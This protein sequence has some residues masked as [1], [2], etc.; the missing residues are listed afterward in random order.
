LKKLIEVAFPLNASHRAASWECRQSSRLAATRFWWSKKSQI[1]IRALIFAAL[2]DDP[3]ANPAAFPT[4]EAQMAERDR[5]FGILEKILALKESADD[6]VLK[7]A[8]AEIQKSL[9]DS[10]LSFFDPFAG[11][12]SFALEAQRLGLKVVASDLNPVA[13]AINKAL[14]EIPLKF[15]DLSPVN[16]AGTW[17]Y[18]ERQWSGS[19]GLAEDFVHYAEVLRNR[20]SRLL[21]HLYPFAKT[22]DS[23]GEVKEI[24]VFA[25]LW[26]R[27]IKCPYAH[28][29]HVIPLSRSFALSRRKTNVYAYPVLNPDRVTF[30]IQKGKTD[31]KGSFDDRGPKCLYCES[32]LDWSYVKTE[33]QNGGLD[34]T[35]MAIVGETQDGGLTYLSP[36]VYHERV[37]SVPRPYLPF[38]QNLDL[39]L[40]TSKFGF[41]RFSSLFTARQL[42]YLTTLLDLTKDLAKEIKADALN[43]GLADDDLDLELGGLGAKAYSQAIVVYLSLLLYQTIN[44][45]STIC[46]WDSFHELVSHTI[47]FQNLSMTWSFAENNPLN[48]N[49]TKIIF[50]IGDFIKNLPANTE[51]YAYK[52][53]AKI[54][55]LVRNSLVF[56]DTPFY[57]STSLASVSDFFYIFLRQSLESV[58]S[59][60]FNT[61]L[62]P[63]NGELLADP[64][65]RDGDLTVARQSFAADLKQVLANVRQNQAPSSPSLFY[66]EFNPKDFNEN[67]PK[68]KI[69][70]PGWEDFVA[71]LIEAGFMVTALWPL[72]FE[73]EYKKVSLEKAPR[74]TA[75]IVVCR[76]RPLDA[77]TRLRRDFSRQ[78]FEELPPI[79]AELIRLRT[80]RADMRIVT[81]GFALNVFSRHEAVVRTDGSKISV[82]E[83]I[84][85]IDEALKNNKGFS[86]GVRPKVEDNYPPALSINPEDDDQIKSYQPQPL[87]LKCPSQITDPS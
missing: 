49:F 83:A 36:S 61:L 47:D 1:A 41:N 87:T 57:S 2:V 53:N 64:T 86:G 22:P 40:R 67:C 12:G 43:A 9:G 11:D 74:P 78:L 17:L 23:K 10:A 75:I 80:H 29:G 31:K 27:T 8:R 51:A 77:Q 81:L 25:W 15:A 82:K 35:L 44:Y 45:N 62:V 46:E 58:Y 65:L 70:E 63:K 37:A 38:D 85:I 5:L 28:C 32:P 54:D 59:S 55:S 69:D 16:P 56:T 84:K 50:K 39:G 6:E 72:R 14:L 13:V 71:T 7:V 79:V 34:L 19:H 30:T 24:P 52:S 33:S 3:T 18:K 76:P 20:S 4:L 66:Y 26:T 73:T 42:I 21:S 60:L 68:S 48:I